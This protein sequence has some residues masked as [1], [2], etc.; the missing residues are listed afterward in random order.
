[1]LNH[2]VVSDESGMVE[3]ESHAESQEIEYTVPAAQRDL[4]SDGIA[5]AKSA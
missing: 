4:R 5:H 2:L 1:M 3:E